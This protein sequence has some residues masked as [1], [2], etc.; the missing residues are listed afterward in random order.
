M[1]TFV[2]VQFVI[3]WASNNIF[4]HFSPSFYFILACALLFPPKINEHVHYPCGAPQANM[5][6]AQ[7]HK[8]MGTVS[9]D[10]C[11]VSQVLISG[12]HC[13]TPQGHTPHATTPQANILWIHDLK[14]KKIDNCYRADNFFKFCMEFPLDLSLDFIRGTHLLGPYFPRW[15]PKSKMAARKI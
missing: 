12:V 14:V 1:Y 8:V 9:G 2:R 15:R 6:P 10:D 13:T 3:I 11:I 4:G 5:W 7:G